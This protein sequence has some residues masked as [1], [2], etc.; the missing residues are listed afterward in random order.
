MPMFASIGRVSERAHTIQSAGTCT[1]RCLEVE[2]HGLLRPRHSPCRPCS[3]CPKTHWTR[4]HWTRSQRRCLWNPRRVN[5]LQGQ[6]LD[7]VNSVSVT[8]MWRTTPTASTARIWQKCAKSQRSE[9]QR[10]RA[11][12]PP[13]RPSVPQ[14]RPQVSTVPPRR[15]RGRSPKR[16]ASRRQRSPTEPGT[17]R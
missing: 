9:S 6:R 1:S 11:G 3:L 5:L 12:A 4:S 7:L 13:S 8:Q 2:G 14:L 16:G 15:W 17:R 10:R